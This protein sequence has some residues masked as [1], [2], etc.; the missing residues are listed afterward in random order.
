MHEYR[1]QYIGD[2]AQSMR[3][4]LTLKY[5]LE[6][7]IVLNWD[8]MESIWTYTY[9][10]LRVESQDFP[11]L[12]TEAPLNPKYN[13]ERMLQIMFETFEVPCLYIAVQAVMALYSTGRTTGTV[14]DCGDGVSH[15]VPVYEG[16][17]LPHATQRMNL[18]GRDLTKYMMRILMERGYS[19]TTSAE[20]EIIRDIKEKLSY[21]A[22]D[23]DRELRESETSDKCE[24]LYMLPDGQSIR[25]ANERFR[26]PEVLFN[27]SML[28]MDIVGIHESIYNCVRKCDVDIRK[29]LLENILL[30]GG[31]T[32]LPGLGERLHKEIATLVNPRDPGRVR[33]ISP[34]DRKHAVWSG[35]AVLAGLSTFPQMCISVQEYDEMGPEIVHRKCF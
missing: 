30:S 31:S 14:F 24:E 5:P 6:H 4:V 11:A 35:S 22:L 9:D 26:C 10:Q 7:G 23:F 27:P 18:A 33:V 25:V 28:G 29:D 13:R 34:D 15:T 19:F 1:D 12:L 17:W 8:D 16:Y 20:T 2:D 32:L 21:V 3:G